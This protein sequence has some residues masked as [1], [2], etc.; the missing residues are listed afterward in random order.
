M[1]T[2]K[3][4]KGCR[5]KVILARFLYQLYLANAVL[6]QEVLW[7]KK[8]GCARRNHLVPEYKSGLP[9]PNQGSA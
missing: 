8:R 9:Q 2:F 5:H 1:C 3:S 6:F 4:K 7:E